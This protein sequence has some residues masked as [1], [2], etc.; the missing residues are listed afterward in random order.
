MFIKTEKKDR[1]YAAVVQSVPNGYKVTQ[2][3]VC[4]INRFKANQI[5]YLKAA[6][7]K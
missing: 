2:K 6:D 3:T 7:A 4:Y 5:P 1:H